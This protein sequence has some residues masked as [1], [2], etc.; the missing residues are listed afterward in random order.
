MMRR[1][2]QSGILTDRPTV[3]VVGG[4]FGGV[5]C[6]RALRKAN[7]NVVLIDRNNHSLFQPLLYQVATGAL[8]PADI[9]TPLRHLLKKQKKLS[10]YD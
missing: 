3:A 8:S 1:S 4:G 9:A 10:R 7:A 2:P 5:E 6:A